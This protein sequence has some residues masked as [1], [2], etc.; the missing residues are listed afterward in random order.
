MP[1]G[2]WS[3]LL[4]VRTSMRDLGLRKAPESAWVDVG[5]EFSHF[6]VAVRNSRCIIKRVKVDRVRFGH[7][8]ELDR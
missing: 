8:P 3:K 5:S 6:V 7:S 2:D 4:E 1:G